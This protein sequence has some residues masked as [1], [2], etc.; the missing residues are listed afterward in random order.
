MKHTVLF[1]LVLLLLPLTGFRTIPGHGLLGGLFIDHTFQGGVL[2]AF[3]LLGAAWGLMYGQ[4]LVIGTARDKYGSRG[5]SGE[6]VLDRGWEELLNIPIVPKQFWLYTGLAGP[7][8]LVSIL[9]SQARPGHPVHSVLLGGLAALLG[10]GL[11]FLVWQ[12]LFVPVMMARWKLLGGDRESY[13]QSLGQPGGPPEEMRLFFGTAWCFRH[14]WTRGPFASLRGPAAAFYHA[15]S[16][17]LRPVGRMVAP[18]RVLEREDG[19]DPRHFA[20]LSIV[21]PLALGYLLAGLLLEDGRVLAVYYLYTLLALCI[22]TLTAV[23]FYATVLF[24]RPVP[25]LLGTASAALLGYSLFGAGHGYRATVPD[26]SEASNLALLDPVEVMKASREGE[27]LVV[28]TSTGGGIYAAGWTSLMLKRLCESDAAF[29]DKT[30]LVSSVSGSSV[31]MAF[32]AE[33]QL[34]QPL[35]LRSKQLGEV[36]HGSTGSSLSAAARGLAYPDFWRLASCGLWPRG[37][38]AP[39]QDRGRLQELSWMRNAGAG[40]SPPRRLSD[41]RSAIRA[42]RLP[43]LIFNASTMETGERVMITP[44]D[45]PSSAHQARGRT[46]SELLRRD[47]EGAFGADLSLWTAARLSA[48]FPYVSPMARGIPAPEPGPWGEGA[49][50]HLGD[51]G[52]V[53]NYGVASALDWLDPLL[54]ARAAGHPDLRFRRVLILQL[55]AFRAAEAHAAGEAA[56]AFLGPA[57]GQ[58]GVHGGVRHRNEIE[59]G[60]FLSHWNARLKAQGVQVATEVLQPD[61]DTDPGPMSWHLTTRDHDLLK[62]AGDPDRRDARTGLPANPELRAAFDRIRRHLATP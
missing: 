56:A 53:D 5:G 60:R 61:R 15:C 49:A 14:V 47:S 41:L 55:R 8:L 20:A 18:L 26:R 42:G 3:Q 58:A 28:I 9:G 29:L 33:A 11:S 36:L 19:L 13:L 44:V 1:G 39:F 45:F 46:H 10:G 50:L 25:A 22:W 4:G 16:W 24:R 52:Y 59:L 38:E 34:K 51:G 2:A 27:H 31:A 17:L 12:L 48:T 6:A 43:A 54:E 37:S 30:R 40:S 7:G 23:D 62:Q 57:L 35:P 32:L 21:G